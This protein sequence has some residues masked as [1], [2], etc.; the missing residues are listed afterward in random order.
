M[1]SIRQLLYISEVFGLVLI[2]IP[3][4]HPHFVPVD[5]DLTALRYDMT[6]MFAENFI[7]LNCKTQSNANLNLTYQQLV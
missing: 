5:S 7:L 6:Y 1:G 3:L 2:T 4:F